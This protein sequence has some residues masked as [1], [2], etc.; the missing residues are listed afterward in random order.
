MSAITDVE[1]WLSAYARFKGL[2]QEIIH[3]AGIDGKIFE[4]RPADLRELVR[5][6]K[7]APPEIAC[8]LDGEGDWWLYAEA[9]HSW[10]SVTGNSRASLDHWLADTRPSTILGFEGGIAE[11][12]ERYGVRG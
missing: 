11:I 5:L 12:A 9:S 8:L 1:D 2:D 4:L 6:A 7:L 10:I 3:S